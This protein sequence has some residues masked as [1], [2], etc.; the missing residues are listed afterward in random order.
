MKKLNIQIGDRFGKLTVIKEIDRKSKNYRRFLWKCD[1]GNEIEID[2]IPVKRGNSNS[3]GCIRANYVRNQ[4]KGSESCSW[5]GGRI[6]EDG[7][8]LIY[9]PD[10]VHAK[11]NGYVREHKY[12]MSEY[13]GRPLLKYENVHH[14]NGNK[15]DNRIENLELWSTSQP[16][17]Q[18]VVDK[19]KWAN[20]I[21]K[22]YGNIN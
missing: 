20:E 16:C 8:V 22:L 19:L 6:V 7:Y 3:C 11:S 9:K 2:L 12:V 21:I 13:L 1:C 18:R 10:H 5:K 14:I 4:K 15:E 17:G